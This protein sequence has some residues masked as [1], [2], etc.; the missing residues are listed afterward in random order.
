MLRNITSRVWKYLHFPGKF[1]I[2]F[3]S[4][5]NDRK[6]VR[7][8]QIGVSLFP[9]LRSKYVICHNMLGGNGQKISDWLQKNCFSVSCKLSS[10]E[11]KSYKKVIWNLKRKT[12]YYGGCKKKIRYFLNL[13]HWPLSI[14]PDFVVGSTET[15]DHWKFPTFFRWKLP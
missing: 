11:L 1:D 7:E 14:G 12:T 6:Y 15:L 3:V 8:W 10:A 9:L 4:E 13:S 5:D 2:L